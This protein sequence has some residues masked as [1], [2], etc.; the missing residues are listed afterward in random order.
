[1]LSKKMEKD[2][3]KQVNWELYSAYVYM[4]M[5]AYLEHKGLKGF[6]N[7]MR[8]Q[9]QE[10]MTHAMKIYDYI[11]SRGGRA[12]MESIEGP[13]TNWKNIIEVFKD[14]LEH[15]QFVT[16]RI[17]GLANLANQEKDHATASFLQWFVDEQ[18]EEEESAS[19]MLD[20]LKLVEGKGAG[21]FMLD[22]E[23]QQRVFVP[24]PAEGN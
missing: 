11:N 1:M 16:S 22:R 6:A 5:S 10:E 2:L 18:V 4:S 8:I 19:E 14:T 24:P 3:N 21:L 12:L 23:A 17:N 15:E 9:A 20:Q 7:W 13:K